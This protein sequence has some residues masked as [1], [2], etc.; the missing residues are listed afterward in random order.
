VR[1]NTSD[2]HLRENSAPA[3]GKGGFWHHL[4][5][6]TVCSSGVAGTVAGFGCTP[7][8][9]ALA[10]PSAPLQEEMWFLPAVGAIGLLI[11][12]LTWLGITRSR[13]SVQRNAAL[14][15]EIG[16]R[17]R[18]EAQL[19]KT[20]DE[21]EQ[22]VAERTKEL[23]T[24]YESLVKEIAER[25]QA[26]ETRR[27]LEEQLRQAQKMK[28]IGTLAGGIAH[29]FNNI[30]TVIIPCTHLALEDAGDNPS[31]RENLQQVLLAADRAR[32]LVQQILAFSRQQKQERGVI[33]LEP[34]V[35]ESHKLLR[36]A[37]PSTIQIVYHAEPGLPPV[38]AD[39]TQI[40][41]VVMNLCSNAE[42]ALRGRQGCIEI[43]LDS[44]AID[45]AYAQRHPDLR[46]GRY[47]RLSVHD[48]GTGMTEDI[49]KRIF[50]PFFTT[51]APGE[52]TGLGLSVVHGIVKDHEGAILVH[53]QPGEGTTFEVHLPAQMADTVP[54]IALTTSGPRGRGEHILLVDDEAPVTRALSKT[55]EQAGYHVTAHTQPQTA[56]EEFRFAPQTF[57]LVITDLTMPGLT[58][59]Q[60]SQQVQRIR[61][62]LP[63][64][65]VTGFG[66][67]WEQQNLESLGIRKVVIKPFHPQA[68]LWLVHDV[69]P[70]EKR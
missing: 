34:I 23:S 57:D 41:Q 19:Q 16:E 8:A 5:R 50:D 3:E 69:L 4:C 9:L 21:L 54:E 43:K 52:G 2:L 7:A 56:L 49:Q 64:M 28:A 13:Q 61:P 12:F 59:L 31:V 35:K 18:A 24:A 70:S 48:N 58:G 10:P 40:L 38:L 62:D 60:F 25:K 36:S 26:E 22:R 45:E 39:P 14:Q 55:L 33:D 53:S 44:V 15:A 51:K 65:L 46:P 47:T 27:Q 66:G 30:L 29:D 32:H 11:C 63:I 42:H 1:L 6:L 17:R 20:Y 37:L 68:I 67:E